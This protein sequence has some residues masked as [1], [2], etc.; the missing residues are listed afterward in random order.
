MKTLT[1]KEA[2]EKG[3]C[4]RPPALCEGALRVAVDDLSIDV[5][6]IVYA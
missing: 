2:E 5:G 4:K 6:S 1:E 3:R